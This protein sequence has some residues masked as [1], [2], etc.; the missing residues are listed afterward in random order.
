VTNDFFILPHELPTNAARGQLHAPPHT[1]CGAHTQSV[2]PTHSLP[3]ADWPADE[4]R[5]VSQGRPETLRGHFWPGR[6]VNGAQFGPVQMVQRSSLVRRS[7]PSG[8]LQPPSANLSSSGRRDELAELAQKAANWPQA[9]EETEVLVCVRVYLLVLVSI[10]ASVCLCFSL[11][12]CVWP[13]S[14]VL[15]CCGRTE[16]GWLWM[17]FAA[18]LLVR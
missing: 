12:L 8:R 9:Q 14:C 5:P 18:D 13:C 1:V 4:R 3:A 6:A 15:V 16:S 2:G 17:Q 10:F 11:F 7:G